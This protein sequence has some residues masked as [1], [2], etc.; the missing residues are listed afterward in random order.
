MLHFPITLPNAVSAIQSA[1][2]LPHT[3]L[4]NAYI[5]DAIIT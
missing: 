1:V 2:K 3:I 5:I 4:C